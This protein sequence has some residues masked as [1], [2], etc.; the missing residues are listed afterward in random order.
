MASAF[1]QQERL[2]IDKALKESAREFATTVGMKKTTVDL[3][4]SRAGISKGA[5]YNFYETKEHLFFELLE[6]WH[7]EL[8]GA[9]WLK[10][11]SC[12]GLPPSLRAA[13][14]L[15]EICR[16]LEQNSMMS[17]ME[18]DMPY[19]LRKIP[20]E[21]LEKH[22][23]SDDTHIE[24]LLRRMDVT[25]KQPISVVS[26]TIRALFFTLSNR[27]GIGEA[28]PQALRL[29]VLGICQQLID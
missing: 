2:A 14:V 19:L 26:A 25:L 23:H 20:E 1:T 17:F 10:W 29:I 27:K 28:Y 9:A 24:D 4:A 3:L 18:E 22:Y 16:L 5:F 15:L 8:Y 11:Q 6:I 12:E 21:D 7:T 13:E